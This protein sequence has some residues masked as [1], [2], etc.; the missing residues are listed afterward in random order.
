MKQEVIEL[1]FM[2]FRQARPAQFTIRALHDEVWWE[3]HAVRQQRLLIERPAQ[4]RIKAVATVGET[5]SH[6]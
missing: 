6:D 1:L 3:L 5:V 4:A 2:T